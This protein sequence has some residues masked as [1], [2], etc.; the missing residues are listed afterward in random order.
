[1]ATG[2]KA[3]RKLNTQD[4]VITV[5][6][7]CVIGVFSDIHGIRVIVLDWDNNNDS[8]REALLSNQSS[9]IAS[10][11]SEMPDD[12]RLAYECSISEP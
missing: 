6:G 4:V 10:N 9:N 1:M 2:P 7:G 8:P 5:L 12:A 11:M 3:I